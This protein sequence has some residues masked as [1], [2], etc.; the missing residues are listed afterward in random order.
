MLQ[1]QRQLLV[2]G[3]LSRRQSSKVDHSSTKL[4]NAYKIPV[5]SISCHEK[6]PLLLGYA[7]QLFITSLRET[8]FRYTN[9]IVPKT[10]QVTTCGSTQEGQGFPPSRTLAGHPDGSTRRLPY[11]R[12]RQSTL[13]PPIQTLSTCYFGIALA[14]IRSFLSRKREWISMCF[15]IAFV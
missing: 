6:T 8:Q 10:T 11:R 15:L 7:E 5:V 14:S 2:D 1:D 12:Y 9:S 3:I 4:P 13:S